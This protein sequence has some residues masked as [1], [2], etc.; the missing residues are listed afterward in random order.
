MPSATHLTA[1]PTTPAPTGSQMRSAAPYEP[2]DGPGMLPVVPQTFFETPSYATAR[3][4]AHISLKK[5]WICAFEG[6][7]GTG[8]TTAAAKLAQASGRPFVYVECAKN[9]PIPD[10]TAALYEAVTGEPVTRYSKQRDM[11][12]D[13]IKVLVRDRMGI[14]ADDVHITGV[15]GMQVLRYLHDEVVRYRR[16]TN[17]GFPLWLVGGDV[18]A[19]ITPVRELRSRVRSAAPF[20]AVHSGDLIAAV[21]SVSPRIAN[22]DDALLARLKGVAKG[23]L[24]DWSTIV[25]TADL[26]WP[27]DT[28]LT[29]THIDQL[30][31]TNPAAA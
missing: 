14:I 21:R 27:G 16:T 18:L 4:A 5:D 10:L 9:A 17:N 13:I 1:A 24:R 23:N 8:K 11:R 3:I 31:L 7:H 20:E 15:P 25:D 29:E 6:E 28:P 30:L 12:R 2:L 19:A 22:L 26:L